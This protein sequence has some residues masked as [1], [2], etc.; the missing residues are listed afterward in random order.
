MNVRNLVL[1]LGIVIVFAL[2]LWQ[3]LEA[4]YP[5]PDYD[6]Y[7][8]EARPAEFIETQHRCEEIGGFWEFSEVPGKDGMNG[9][10]DLDYYCR[11]DWESDRQGYSQVVFII[12]L[13]IAVL[14]FILGYTLLKTEPVGSALLLSGVWSVVY[15]TVVNWTNFSNIWRFVLLLAALVILIWIALRP[16][17]TKKWFMFWK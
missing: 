11:Q 16:K 8:P 1:G 3:G 4:F 14:V 17:K 13:I 7:C 2:V 6:D 12:S 15:G 5:G 9:Y 10:C